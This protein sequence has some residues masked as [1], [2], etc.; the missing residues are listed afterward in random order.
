[1]HKMLLFLFCKSFYFEILNKQ[2]NKRIACFFKKNT[3]L[4]AFA[5]QEYLMLKRLDTQQATA[6]QSVEWFKNFCF[7]LKKN[8]NV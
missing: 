4:R 5:R 2:K 8:K 6:L 1:M 7:F 3:H